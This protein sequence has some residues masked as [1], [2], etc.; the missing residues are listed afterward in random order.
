MATTSHSGDPFG[1][2]ASLDTE[3]GS[4]DY[5]SLAVLEDRAEAK[6]DKIPVTVKILLENLLRT[7]GTEHASEEEVN[8]LA[9]WGQ[10]PI[11]DREFPFSP[12]RVILQDFTGV[13][14]VVDLAA[15]RAAMDREGGDPGRVDPLVPVDLVIDHSVQVDAFA[16]DN[17][18]TIN[19]ERESVSYTHLT[20]PTTPYV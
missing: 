11:E 5:F 17:A 6:L 9:V 4:L 15:M 18:F 14:A 7:S 10:K 19:V 16:S 2:R 8:S 1:A 12:A 13:P 3:A 20:L